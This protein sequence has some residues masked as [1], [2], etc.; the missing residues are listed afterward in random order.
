MGHEIEDGKMI[1]NVS[2]GE[3][4]H[5]LGK[6]VQG[7]STASDVLM[8]AGWDFQVEKQPIFTKTGIEIPDRWAMIRDVDKKPVGIVGNRYTAFQPNEVLA[9]CDAI[10]EN[11]DGAH[12]DTAG[13][14]FGGRKIWC[15]IK[16]S[17]TPMNIN[18]DEVYKYLVG[19]N[20][21]DGST[22]FSLLITNIRVVCHNTL[23]AAIGGC[24]NIVRIRHTQ[25]IH[26]RVEDAKRTLQLANRYHANWEEQA[27]KLAEVEITDRMFN[28][29]LHA[30]FPDSQ[31]D[32]KKR[33]AMTEEER[34]DFVTRSERT[35][36]NILGIYQNSTTL[37]NIR[38]TVW[39][40]YN[41]VTEYTDH[42]ASVK[43]KGSQSEKRLDRQWFGT[44]RDLKT[45]AWDYAVKLAN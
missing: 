33:D 40:G 28:T 10:V 35:R 42:H 9:V 36:A 21:F 7:Y 16:L 20:S 12:Y 23:S 24:D 34:L 1:Y 2:E 15:M 11:E 22:H 14:L 30:L 6:A 13:V 5:G 3:P 26:E 8:L 31:N 27:K 45:K 41:A 19:Y 29:Y 43:G 25:S 4:W 44:H 18:G 38:G 39:G 37:T 17:E 32:N